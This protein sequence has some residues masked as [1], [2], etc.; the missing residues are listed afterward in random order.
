M[1]RGVL[2]GSLVR[3]DGEVHTWTV[4]RIR[5]RCECCVPV[6]E[7][8]RDTGRVQNTRIVSIDRLTAIDTSHDLPKE[9][10]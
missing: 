10:S 3:I 9:Q 7:L 5:R 6:A 2:E 8:V 1:A 4:A